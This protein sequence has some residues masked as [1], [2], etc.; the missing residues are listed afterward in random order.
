MSTLYIDRQQTT[1]QHDAGV[2][3]ICTP[4]DAQPRKIPLKYISRIVI[5]TSTQLPSNLLCA[6][7]QAGIAL[8]ILGGRNG[9]QLAQISGSAHNDARRRWQQVL[10]FSQPQ[11]CAQLAHSIISAKT[12]RQLQTL[13]TLAQHRPDLRKPLFDGCQQL[14][15]SQTTLRTSVSNTSQP[16]SN[17]TCTLNQLRGIEGAAAAAYFAAYFCAFAPALGATGRNR[18]PPRDP[19]NACLSL[20]YTLLY[21]MAH[22][23]CHAAGLDPALGA[24]HTLSHGRAALACDLMEPWRPKIDLWV[25][26]LFRQGTLRPEHFGTDGSGACLLGKAGRTHFYHAWEQHTRTTSRNLTGYARLLAHTLQ[27]QQQTHTWQ[28]LAA[29]P[30]DC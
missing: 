8:T 14:V 15:R 9:T 20:A 26:Q 7:A 19:V 30:T 4:D 17:I 18:R 24:L 28:H 3:S 10:S 12:R 23:A 6:L 21:S 2:L 13:Q 16:S 25:W 22:S 29:S 11:Q 27:N 1:L 5:R